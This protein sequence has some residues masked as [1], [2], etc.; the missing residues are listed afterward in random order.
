M[1]ENGKT[2]VNTK[3]MSISEVVLLIEN[4]DL[5]SFYGQNDQHLNAVRKAYPDVT[6]TSRGG[7]VKMTGEK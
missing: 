6:I 1:P 5:V 3:Y 4:L 2:S 7:M